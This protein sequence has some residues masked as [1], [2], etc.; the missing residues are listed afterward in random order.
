MLTRC[1]NKFRRGFANTVADQSQTLSSIDISPVVELVAS[2]EHAQNKIH[3]AELEV[4]TQLLRASQEVGFFHIVG[5]GISNE[6]KNRAFSDLKSFFNL[7][8]AE[9]MAIHKSHAGTGAVR[10][11]LGMYEQGGYGLDITDGRGDVEDDF[12]LMDCKELFAM[13]HELPLHHPHYHNALFAANLWP[14]MPTGFR[15]SVDG[16]YSELSRVKYAVFRIF[17][18]ALK[19][20]PLYFAPMVSD[21][22]DS[23]NCNYY[24]PLPPDAPPAQSGIAAHTDYE[25]FTLLVQEEDA[26]PG[27]EIWHE[28]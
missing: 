5:H 4:A 15:G 16:L 12:E 19:R 11:Y 14:Q 6:L 3:P 9:K 10:G 23:M 27:L 24:P 17:A 25:C 28:V 7:S 20:P 26:P 22:M 21:G 2:G 13:G 18:V 8:L 1:A